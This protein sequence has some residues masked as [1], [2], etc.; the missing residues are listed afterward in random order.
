MRKSFGQNNRYLIGLIFLTLFLPLS[1]FAFPGWIIT[2]NKSGG[3]C[4]DAH[5]EV[6]SSFARA[7]PDRSSYIDLVI[8]W[9]VVGQSTWI[10]ET[11]PNLPQGLIDGLIYDFNIDP[12]SP[13]NPYSPPVSIEYRVVATLNTPTGGYDLVS[14][15]SHIVHFYTLDA[16]GVPVINNSTI[17]QPNGYRELSN[18]FPQTHLFELNSTNLDLGSVHIQIFES[19]ANGD[20]SG[21]QIFLPWPDSWTRPVGG[22]G[23]PQPD[24]FNF[25]S[26]FNDQVWFPFIENNLG[27][28][29]VIIDYADRCETIDHTEVLHIRINSTPAVVDFEFQMDDPSTPINP[30][31]ILLPPSQDINN[32]VEIGSGSGRVNMASTSPYYA[33]WEMIIEKWDGTT[34]NPAGGYLETSPTYSQLQFNPFN[35]TFYSSNNDNPANNLD[36][37]YKIELILRSP[38]CPD[39]SLMSYFKVP[40]NLANMRFGQTSNSGELDAN[41]HT[42]TSGQNGVKLHIAEQ[43]DVPE[44]NGVFKAKVIAMDGRTVFQSVDVTIGTNYIE[45]PSVSKG[46]YIIQAF[47]KNDQLIYNGKIQL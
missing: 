20:N 1:S 33:E 30:P 40:T 22:P 36:E 37:L 2:L 11:V 38:N 5:F 32:P 19:N 14:D 12:T 17:N 15:Q 13:P 44:N 10:T 46:V 35:P 42:Q 39:A 3:E 16:N 45:L 24:F 31:I 41:W 21:N 9:K 29:L 18:C 25:Q 7:Y 4:S 28:Y 34:F 26:D 27:Y 23:I 47:D 8:Q 43:Y 6:Y